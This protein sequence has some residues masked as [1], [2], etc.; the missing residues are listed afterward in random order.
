MMFAV[1]MAVFPSKYSILYC[2]LFRMGFLLGIPIGLPSSST[3]L[4]FNLANFSS[5]SSPLF[6]PSSIPRYGYVL[7]NYVAYVVS[8][9]FNVASTSFKW[10]LSMTLLNS[11]L[12]YSSSSSRKSSLVCGTSCMCYFR[13]L[14]C[15]SHFCSNFTSND[16]I[17]ALYSSVC[18]SGLVILCTVVQD[19]GMPDLGRIQ[20]D[21]VGQLGG[22][23]PAI[24]RLLLLLVQRCYDT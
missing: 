7:P 23:H 24:D 18:L 9:L 21:T 16:F 20:Q 22:K 13:S 6:R 11:S 4:L 1:S 17:L 10:L 2:R 19:T 14:Y 3:A 8:T 15:T 5:S 12:N